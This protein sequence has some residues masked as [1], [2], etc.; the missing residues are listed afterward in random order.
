MYN[1]ETL[2][3]PSSISE[4]TSPTNVY[5][6][7]GEINSWNF[8]PFFLFSIFT[9]KNIAKFSSKE[10]QKYAVIGWR[11]VRE[12][13]ISSLYLIE[14]QLNRNSV[15]QIRRKKWNRNGVDCNEKGSIE[16][17]FVRTKSG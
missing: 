13:G 6:A 3:K 10:Q 5:A 16:K 12:S 11:T 2:M 9:N 7:F 1:A 17:L 14:E 4:F 15:E 8:L